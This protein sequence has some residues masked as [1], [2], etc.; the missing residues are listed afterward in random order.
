[1]AKYEIPTNSQAESFSIS[2]AGVVYQLS[3]HWCAPT[4]SWILDIADASGQALVS[5][6]P[7]IPGADLL[8]QYEY[9]GIGGQLIAV[10]DGN[11]AAPS[12]TGLGTTG[13]IYFVTL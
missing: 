11:A 9:L 13:H 6:I 12:F 7:V 3:L 4:N 1:M 2:L 5:G 8:A 10:V